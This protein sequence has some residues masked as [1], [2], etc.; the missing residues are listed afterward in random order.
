MQP[1]LNHA[2][3][4]LCLAG[5]AS[6]FGA[7]AEVSAPGANASSP[8]LAVVGNI[9]HAAWAECGAE[10]CS[11]MYAN[12]TSGGDMH[13]IEIAASESAPQVRIASDAGG[14]LAIVWKA[15]TAFYYS[16]STD[17]GLFWSPAAQIPGTEA[18]DGPFDFAAG[19]NGTA[20]LVWVS[21]G[22]LSLS[23]FIGG[24]WKD[25][26]VLDYGTAGQPRIAANPKGGYGIVWT[27]GSSGEIQFMDTPSGRE[28]DVSNTV[29]NSEAP[30]IAFDTSGTAHIAWRDA[31]D[32]SGSLPG[33]WDVWYAQFSCTCSGIKE[34]KDI[35]NTPGSASY[36]PVISADQHDNIH[37]IWADNATGTLSLFYSKSS[38]GG[39]GWSSPLPVQWTADS[40]EAPFIAA[41]GEGR[42]H[43]LWEATTPSGHA[44]MHAG[45][46]GSA[47]V[48]GENISTSASP[49]DYSAAI[50]G[51]NRLHTLFAAG[52]KVYYALD[53][54]FGRSEERQLRLAVAA[55]GCIGQ[56]LA[57]RATDESG[58]PIANVFIHSGIFNNVVNPCFGAVLI[59]HQR[60]IS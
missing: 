39:A 12:T 31:N 1:V 27:N 19:A 38:D 4:F 20:A 36:A 60:N 42:P 43:I 29:G 52:G 16:I 35:S 8:W 33:Q 55:E 11:V 5:I 13:P 7:P 46:N 15:Q 37:A 21:G 45:W 34:K 54:G 25:P 51:M 48:G 44:L 58:N 18:A 24:T 23:K 3:F 10:N 26:G 9:A 56:P 57:I 6:A 40:P 22:N 30:D 53:Q 49:I 41:D 59:C 2:V 14:N 28:Y 17:R 50:D 32:T 47:W